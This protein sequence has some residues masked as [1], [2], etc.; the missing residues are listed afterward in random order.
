MYVSHFIVVWLVAKLADKFI[1]YLVQPE[2][3]L[4]ACFF[5]VAA[6]TFQVA[7]FTE[8]MVENRGIAF[9]RQI[10]ARLHSLPQTR[11]LKVSQ[12]ESF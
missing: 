12:Q 11:R 10:V 8:K 4:G 7:I 9:G 5:F 6:I 3:V 2:L 1:P